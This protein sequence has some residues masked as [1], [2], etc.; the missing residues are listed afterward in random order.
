MTILEIYEKYNIMPNL[1]LHQLRVA[2]VAEQI[3]EA[4]TT[5]V[6]KE[7]IVLACLLHDMG[8]IIKSKFD[9]LYKMTEE[10]VLYWSKVKEEFIQKYGSNETMATIA[11]LKELEVSEFI[12]DMI[13]DSDFAHIC[14]MLHSDLTEKQ[15]MKYADLRVGPYGVVSLAERL[16]DGKNRY[17][18][19]E[20]E[21]TECAYE[22]EKHIFSHTNIKPEDITDESIKHRIEK[23]RNTNI[24]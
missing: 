18:A 11:I 22:I 6:D 23:L 15:L 9:T 17:G 21:K 20:E 7:S 13:K 24:L 1:Q 19:W 5:P 16:E 12:Q 2:A 8:N 4:S 14:E 10:E 3:C